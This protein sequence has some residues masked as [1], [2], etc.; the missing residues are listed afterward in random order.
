[1]IKLEVWPLIIFD[2]EAFDKD[3]GDLAVVIAQAREVFALDIAMDDAY[4][5]QKWSSSSQ[6]YI[7]NKV[8]FVLLTYFITYNLH[9]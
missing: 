1:M 5:D 8:Y 2:E 7:C 6:Y 3:D 9:F 4:A